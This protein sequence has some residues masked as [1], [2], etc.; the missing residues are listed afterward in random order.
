[1]KFN[2]NT[3]VGR[4]VKILTYLL[5]LLI[6]HFGMTQSSVLSSGD[7]YKIGIT[8]SGVYKI[9]RS[10][11][12]SLGINVNS[13]NPQ[14]IA[15]YGNGVNGI[16]PQSI[17]EYRPVDL[18]EN[19]IQVEGE[20][21]GSFDENDFI[22]FYGVGPDREEWT[23]DG[24]SFEKNIYSD[25]AYYF[26][27]LK[28]E[29]G[30]RISSQ[31]SLVGDAISV[32]TYN[33]AIAFEEDENNIVKSGR[34]WFGKL[35]GNNERLNFTYT[36]DGI[37]S[38]ILF[39]VRAIGVSPEPNEFIFSANDSEIG[40]FEM[41]DIPTGDGSTYTI[42]A[43]EA[44]GTFLINQA[45]TID[46]E[47]EFDA[48]SAS[49]RGFLDFYIMTFD[50][51]LALYGD[52]TNFRS[53]DE[54]GNLIEYQVQNATS[55]QLWNI[56]DPINIVS[57]DYDVNGSTASFKS[58]SSEIEEFVVFSLSNLPTPSLFGMVTNQNLRVDVNYEGI[59]VA[60][61]NFLGAAENLA[62][63]H[64]TQDGL[65]I[66][67][68]TPLQIYNEFSSGRQDV[69]AIRDY[70]KHVY[71]D[72]GLL[73]Y[74]LL[75]GDCSY[76]YKNRILENTNFVP[77]YESRESFLPVLTYSS[78]DYFGFFEEDE[79]E[80]IESSVGDHTME[81]GIGRLPVKTS[82]EA[83]ALVDKI[84]Y[85]TTS[86]NTL[87]KWR[88]QISYLADDGDL[89]THAEHAE[90]LAELIDTTYAQYR[91][92]KI[93]LD[94]FNQE[95]GATRETSPETTRALKARIKEGSFIINFMGHGN[96]RQWMDEVVLTQ[97]LIRDLTN[98]NKLPIFVTA[99]CEFGRYD[100]PVEVSG[101]E[102]L[103]LSETGGGIALLTTSRPVV[104]YTN[105]ELNE[106]FH[107]NIFRKV[108]GQ[109]QRLG[110][111]IRLTKNEGLAGAN[112]R[113]FTL[114]GD[115]MMTLAFPQL[116]IEI[117]ELANSQDTLSALEE[118]TFTG[119]I[120]EG[121][122]V[123][124]GFNGVLDIVFFDEKQTFR[125]KG[126]QSSPF[127]Y[128]VRNNAL[129][130]GESTVT[131][132]TFTFSFVVPKTISYQFNKGKM[133]L[134]AWDEE[135]N[136]DAAGSSRN[137]VIGGTEQNVIQD[138]LPPIIEMFLNDESFQSG[139]TVSS[140]SLLIANITDENGVT[141]TGNGLIQGIT[142][143]LGGEDINLNAFYTSDLDTYQTGK[144][145]YPIQDLDPGRYFATLRVY[146]THNNL[147]T[148]QIEFVVSDESF[149]SLFN[150]MAYPNPVSDRAIFSFEHD[151]EEQDL[152][153][154]LLV[155]NSHGEVVSKKMYEFE[156]S[157]RLIE[158]DWYANTNSGQRLNQGV[159]F[160]RLI[161]GSRFDGAVK[162]IA[163]K[164]VIL[165]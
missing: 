120:V 23:E 40:R 8:E 135:S 150:M 118:V 56:T 90:L 132:G 32:N 13:I 3:D 155:Y 98:R 112:N 153:V 58:Q 34:Q 27:H 84:I 35:L 38:D 159:Y 122:N 93:L 66:K 42:K 17:A 152:E 103:L 85:Y 131:N 10:T 117:N 83:S 86:P 63:F 5:L 82:A 161:V 144:V 89:N 49:G 121:G 156:N 43:R 96:E 60:H 16:L 133:S 4:V 74:L 163:N 140:S 59:I 31:P 12:S 147:S 62:Q 29:Q 146:D 72:G 80:W 76:D 129:F 102:N 154:T 94:A 95:E 9:D 1:M 30:K 14:Q 2:R 48:N 127:D 20:S 113:N 75:F 111:I 65:S 151:R 165:D 114:L 36:V 136:I 21:D 54:I 57:Q 139:S 67:V 106:S 141:T 126:Q 78:D 105:F 149:L 157:D 61:P 7:W 47:I 128:T 110:D 124:T 134:Y 115:P 101:A 64:R 123:N 55:A 108:D 99:T 11:L 46:L 130:R 137:Y 77:T 162:E 107:R 22:L 24:F 91:I 51:E 125:T 44:S 164:L 37:S 142:L 160:Y 73:K 25:T 18:L 145:V 81:I 138:D 33:D 26:L 119:Q 71:D 15:I 19:A 104:A 143:N 109:S 100:N 92:D 39:S 148:K 97:S 53:V 87:G 79:G 158:V 116:D 45:S 28:S 41:P 6:G 88:N 50:R 52:R 70:A 68:V 69:S